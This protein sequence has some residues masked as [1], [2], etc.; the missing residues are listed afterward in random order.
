MIRLA[1]FPTNYCCR[2]TI[3]VVYIVDQNIPPLFYDVMYRMPYLE[4]Q[5][6]IKET[7]KQVRRKRCTIVCFWQSNVS[8]AHVSSLDFFMVGSVLLNLLV[9]CDVF[10]VLFAMC[11]FLLVSLVHPFM[12]ALCFFLMF[13]VMV[14]SITSCAFDVGCTASGYPFWRGCTNLWKN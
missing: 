9:L 7:R 11:T 4:L 13:F 12:I 3:R 10:F 6:A 8:S 5:H 1:F 2:I 14:D